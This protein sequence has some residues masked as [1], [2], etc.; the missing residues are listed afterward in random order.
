M[1]KKSSYRKD[2]FFGPLHII[3]YPLLRDKFYGAVLLKSYGYP[4][5]F[6]IYLGRLMFVFRRREY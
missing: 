6:E 4:S 3:R 1:E 2:W 5:D